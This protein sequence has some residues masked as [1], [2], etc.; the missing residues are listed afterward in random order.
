MYVYFNL[1]SDIN[2][3]FYHFLNIHILIIVLQAIWLLF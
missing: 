3:K 1:N 2:N